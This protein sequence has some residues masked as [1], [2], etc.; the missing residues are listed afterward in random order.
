MRL[1]G[2]L[3][4]SSSQSTFSWQFVGQPEKPGEPVKNGPFGA[5]LSERD[6]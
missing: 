2:F 6:I 5:L 4:S 1:V 3:P